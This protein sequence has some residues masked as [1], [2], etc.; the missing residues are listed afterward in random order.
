MERSI[1][2][3]LKVN[4]LTSSAY[5]TSIPLAKISSSYRFTEDNICN[6]L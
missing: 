4:D 6:I 2:L 5:H 1:P 3:K